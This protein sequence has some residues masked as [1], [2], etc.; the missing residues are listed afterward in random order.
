MTSAGDPVDAWLDTW[1]VEL[2]GVVLRSSELSKRIMFLADV[3]QRVTRDEL[4]DLGLT[5]AEFDILVA[6]RR[7]GSP[8]QLKPNQLARSLLLSR[9]GTTNVTHR[10][11][12]RGLVVREDDATD[13]RSTWL[14]LTPEGVDL[15]ERAVLAGSA[16]H[17]MLFDDVPT[18]V[19]DAASDAL[20]N[21]FAAAA[22]ASGRARRWRR[23]P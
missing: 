16:T 21:V 2:D 8:Y 13:A 1:R 10:L 15:A 20:R 3:L 18:A 12:A 6:L 7:S 19:L 14:R 9:G 4:V 17:D 22:A 5:P 11:V 23:T